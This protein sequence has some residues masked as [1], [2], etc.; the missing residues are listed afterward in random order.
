MGF[1][2]NT[3]TP[4]APTFLIWCRSLSTQL[5]HCTL[6]AIASEN[7]ENLYLL[8]AV[9]CACF[10]TWMFYRGGVV[11][12]SPNPQ[13]GGPPLVSCPRLLIQFIRSYPPYWRPFL[14]LQPEDS[15]CH[16]D[17]DPLPMGLMHIYSRKYGH[18]K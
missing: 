3:V 17:R 6:R 18:Y 8:L 16:G 14:Y 11:S 13:A 10:L 7:S 4:T 5:K 1:V 15:P 2:L 9:C 12:T